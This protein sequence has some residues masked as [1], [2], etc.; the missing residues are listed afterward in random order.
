MP[1]SLA[2]RLFGGFAQLVC[3][4]P[5][6]F[7]L[8]QLVLVGLCA[9]YAWSELEF[10]TQRNDLVE[11]ERSHHRNF[12]EYRENFQSQD[13][14]LVM[15][16]SGDPEKNRQFV[17]RLGARLEAE[18]ELFASVFYKGNLGML[19]S[20]A[21]YFVED[22]SVIGTMEERLREARPLIESFAHVDG[23]EPLLEEINLRFRTASDPSGGEADWS[24][25]IQGLEALE[26]I[27]VQAEAAL[28]RPGLPPSP[29]VEMLFAGGAKAERERYI[30]FQEGRVYLVT[31]R[32]VSREEESK[33]IDRM[34]RLVAM[35]R[36]EVPGVNAGITGAAVLSL[37]EMRQSQKD[38]L[39]ATVV[40]ILLVLALFAAAYREFRRPLMA[41]LCLLAGIS[42]TLAFTTLAVGHLNILTIAFLPMLVGLAI[43][44]GIHLVTRYEEEL[45]LGLDHQG[46]MSKAMVRTGQ[47]ILTSCLTTAGAFFAM[48][49]T[50]FKGIREMGIITSGGLLL[51]LYPMMTILP[52]LLL[53]FRGASRP[54]RKR[55][56]SRSRIEALWLGSP[57]RIALVASLLAAASLVLLPRIRFDYN[58]LNMQSPGL[59]SV[60]LEMRFLEI[61]DK[62]VLFALVI[63]GS[64]E[65][66]RA[67]EAEIAALPTVSGTDSLVKVLDRDPPGRREAIERL[68][69]A[70]ADLEVPVLGDRPVDLDRL[71]Q[72]LS[73]FQG[74]LTMGA[75]HLEGRDPQD[76]LIGRFRSLKEAAGSLQR[77]LDSRSEARTVQ[78]LGAYLRA[79]S[80][81]V[82]ATLGAI[83]SQDAS[84]PPVREDLPGNLRDR[85][86]GRGGGST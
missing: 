85:F 71:S 80:E 43:D 64:L 77:R 50:G 68:R 83:R 73:F 42:Y 36:A 57:A 60:Q 86:I 10:R 61:S 82:Q 48:T 51:S 29:G 66:A 69:E 17:E 59:P 24:A 32:P 46:A 45:D 78:Q 23:L 19:G 79:L 84:G 28:A 11:A 49:L 12:L 65:E 18:P 76:P 37:D 38:T 56:I 30:T 15:V 53:R 7:V 72:A 54:P 31:A 5:L 3:R 52:A 67:L 27:L 4:F 58:L 74:Y 35:T 63:A 34:D 81:D 44:F 9:Q 75:R 26:R 2:Q 47:G 62:S 14:I 6:A 21:L 55:R 25:M 70:A 1:P 41:T 22:N 39:R 13:D 20:K 33:A 40:T 16:E 8:P